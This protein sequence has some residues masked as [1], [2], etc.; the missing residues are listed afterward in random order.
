LVLELL[1]LA[2]YASLFFSSFYG[3]HVLINLEEMSNDDSDSE[4]EE[5]VAP[6][7]QAGPSRKE[8]R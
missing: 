3:L 1:F 5:G 4:E 2:W 6:D 8:R 7:D